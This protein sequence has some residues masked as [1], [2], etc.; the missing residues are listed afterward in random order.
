[1]DRYHLPYNDKGIAIFSDMWESTEKGDI[2]Q[3]RK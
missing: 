1:M 3:W 2:S